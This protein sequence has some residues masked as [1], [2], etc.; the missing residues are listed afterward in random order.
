MKKYAQLIGI[1][2]LYCGTYYGVTI[3]HNQI[4]VPQY[5][6]YNDFLWNNVPIWITINFCA[7]FILL[8]LIFQIKKI[9]L[10]ER[11]ESIGKMS[12][13]TKISWSDFTTL[14]ILGLACGMFYIGILKISFISSAFPGLEGY[15][16]LF[17]QSR[18]FFFILIGLGIVGPLFEEIFFRGI[19]FNS[20]LKYL[21]FSAAF[22]IQ[23][24]IYAFFQPNL[25]IQ[26]TAFFLAIVYGLVYT[27]LRSIWATVWISIV[28]NVFIFTTKQIG[29]HEVVAKFATS[30]KIIIALLSLF[31]IIYSVYAVWKNTSKVIY[32]K[33]IG[34]L[35]LWVGLYFAI[36]LPFLYLWNV[37]IMSIIAIAPFLGEN[38]V[39]G[40]VFYD[41]I[42]LTV[43]YVV[44]KLIHKQSLIKVSNFS[45]IP[46]K[47]A[48]MITILGVAMGIWV[49]CFFKI[50]YLSEKFPQFEQLF[51][52]LTTATFV[53]LVGFLL[54][55]SIYKEVFFRALVYNVLRA[56][57]NIGI[58]VILSGIIYGGLFFNW[59][60]P[61][62]IYATAGAF[63][64]S[65]MFEWYRSIWAPIINEFML[66][67]TYYWFRKVFT[68]WGLSYG[69]V[70][71]TLTVISSVVI[72][73]AMYYLWKN[74]EVS[75]HGGIDVVTQQQSLNMSPIVQVDMGG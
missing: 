48:V 34:N 52:Y 10:K 46:R 16:T 4:I 25:A 38:N 44:M 42:A 43:Y 55:H 45:K 68:A 64:F 71:I 37:K 20:L 23:A 66:F 1:I 60:I 49:Q 59:D 17:M 3:L 51:T 9:A 24:V 11:H 21:P 61:M 7:T 74:R 35:L 54:I 53:I 47:A 29:L 33:M 58:S 69:A 15:I 18:S 73:Y 57:M 27:R 30:T 28:L 65:M 32:N 39:L 22:I 2:L 41:F 31:F 26:C 40:F 14:T 36:Y 63:I 5:K 56:E 62:T 8:F 13:F 70:T 50:P 67:F 19:I 72:V 6:N 12:R 75:K